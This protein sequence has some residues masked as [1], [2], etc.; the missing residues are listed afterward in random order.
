MTTNFNH[1]GIDKLSDD[2]ACQRLMEF[3]HGDDAEGMTAALLE[4]GADELP[5][6]STAPEVEASFDAFMDEISCC[7]N[8]SGEVESIGVSEKQQFSLQ[9]WLRTLYQRGIS[10]IRGILFPDR[11][12]M[13]LIAS[14]CIA[15]I[16]AVITRPV[17][18]ELL[19]HT[20]L[21][22]GSSAIQL[23]GDAQ[24]ETERPAVTPSSATP[25]LI[26]GHDNSITID[27]SGRANSQ[28]T[29]TERQL[30]T[31]PTGIGQTGVAEHGLAGGDNSEVSKT[32]RFLDPGNTNGIL[33]GPNSFFH[34]PFGDLEPVAGKRVQKAAK[35]T[36]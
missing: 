13:T 24:R 8:Q 15:L 10:L 21:G 3:L 14:A 23:M 4:H 5:D 1:N 26:S 17:S 16:V 30:R 29:D 33:G 12:A 34:K 25:A 18:D 7:D 35:D 11:T 28:Q 19:G 31:A 2:E 9:D 6:T 20:D 22:S 32:L 27:V 36:G